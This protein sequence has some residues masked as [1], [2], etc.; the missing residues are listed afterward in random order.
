MKRTQVKRKPRN[1]AETKW[2]RAYLAAHRS[3]EIGP[4]LFAA[5]RPEAGD[6]TGIAVELHERLKR[7][8]GGSPTDASIIS[9]TCRS[10]HEFTEREVELSTTLHL[11]IPS[12]ERVS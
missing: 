5:G 1:S 4:I 6:C 12:W 10:C 2:R 8:R 11:L 9:A 3:C 7:S